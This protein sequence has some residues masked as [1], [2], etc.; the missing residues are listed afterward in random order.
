MADN[1]D[2]AND[3]EQA[4]LQHA[5]ANARKEETAPQSTQTCLYCH[6]PV[7]P[8]KRWCCVEC[9]DEYEREQ[10]AKQKFGLKSA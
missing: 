10:F 8:P 6:D 9:R 7:K 4:F 2:I 1:I 5:L 3:L